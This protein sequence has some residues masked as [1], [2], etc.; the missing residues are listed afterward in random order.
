MSYEAATAFC[1]KKKRSHNFTRMKCYYSN[2]CLFLCNTELNIWPLA[3]AEKEMQIFFL[4]LLV[5]PACKSSERLMLWTL[6]LLLLRKWNGE[7]VQQRRLVRSCWRFCVNWRNVQTKMLIENK[8]HLILCLLKLCLLWDRHLKFLWIITIKQRLC[9]PLM[10][11]QVHF[12]WTE[13][14][15]EICGEVGGLKTENRLLL[16]VGGCWW[17]GSANVLFP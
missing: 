4:V 6:E 3:L 17:R 12:L 14:C 2:I 13:S 7:K 8:F 9:S 16:S 15:L 10:T 1:C 5:Q 11:L